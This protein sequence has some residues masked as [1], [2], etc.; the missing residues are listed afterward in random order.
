[1]LSFSVASFLELQRFC[2]AVPPTTRP[3]PKFEET[4]PPSEKTVVAADPKLVCPPGQ[5]DDGGFTLVTE[6]PELTLQQ[7]AKKEE[8]QQHLEPQFP[9]GN[10]Q[11]TDSE[12]NVHDV[13]DTSSKAVM[14]EGTPTATASEDT[15]N[16]SP[17]EETSLP[18]AHASSTWTRWYAVWATPGAKIEMR[19]LHHGHQAWEFIKANLEGTEYKRGRDHL[20]GYDTYQ[21]ALEGYRKEC[22]KHGAPWPAVE[23]DHP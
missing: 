11:K 12:T 5:C 3:V 21:E 6:F 22:L 7:S 2:A 16:K 18:S 13:Q 14:K 8:T 20:R 19:G 9:G 1:M 10:K 17:Q 23:F 4:D 15:P